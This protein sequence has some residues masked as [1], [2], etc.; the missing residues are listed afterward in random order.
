MNASAHEMLLTWE[1][2]CAIQQSIHPKYIITITELTYNK[3]A[4]VEL[5][6]SDAKVMSHKF[7]KI[8]NGGIFNVSIK[9]TGAHAEAYVQKVMAPPLPAPRQL[10]VYAE[11]NGTYAIHWKEVTDANERFT[12]QLLVVEGS[13]MNESLTP[14]LTMEA[15]IP[16]LF[17]N[18]SDLG[19][20]ETAGKIF[21]LGV[22]L[23]SEAVSSY[24][25]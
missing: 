25:G 7:G 11:R 13:V 12:Y 10:K 3:T 19:G 18:P 21:T 23:K 8:Q 5:K 6:P 1:N 4:K 15:K 22:R 20:T 16:P 24:I 17:M 2:D 14:V 9:T